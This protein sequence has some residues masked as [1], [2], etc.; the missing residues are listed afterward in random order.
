MGRSPCVVRPGCAVQ[1]PGIGDGLCRGKRAAA[2]FLG[3]ASWQV[4]ERVPAAQQ[5]VADPGGVPSNQLF[6]LEGRGGSALGTGQ[7]TPV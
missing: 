7:H 1:V 3:A 4:E 6:I 2:V 5:S